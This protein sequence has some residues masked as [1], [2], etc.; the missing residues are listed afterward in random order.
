[1]TSQDPSGTTPTGAAPRDGKAAELLAAVRAVESG[2]RSADSFFTER[3]RPPAAPRPQP[4]G[5]PAA[6]EEAEPSRREPMAVPDAVRAVLEEGDAPPALAAR[7]VATLGSEADRVLRGDPWQLLAVPGVRAGQ[8]D[9]FARALLGPQSGPGDGRRSRALV[10]HLLERAALRGHTALPPVSLERGLAQQ[11]VP[12]P[13]AAVREALDDA[14]VLAFE[15]ALDGL[16]ATARAEPADPEPADPPEAAEERPVRLLIGLEHHALAEESLADG[17]AR[18]SG[19]VAPLPE[20]DWIRAAEAAGVAAT[21]TAPELLR[22]VAGH[23][24]AAHTGGEAARAEPAALL[25][26]AERL[27]LRC[28]LV[29][30]GG[31]SLRRLARLIPEA[32]GPEGRLVTL[33]GLLAGREGPPRDTHG[34]WEVDLLVVCDADRLA[35]EEAAALVESLPD[36]ARLVLSGDPHRLGPAGAG[37]V[38]R[39]V[40][41]SRC[42]PVVVSR[43]PDPGPLGTL[44]SSIGAGELPQVDS[45]ER[46][47]VIVPVRDTGEAVHRTVQLVCDSV[48]RALGIPAEDTRAVTVGHGGAAGTRALNEALK[49]RLN[50]GPGRF[51]GFDAGDR[52]VHSPVAGRFEEGTVSGGDEEGLHLDLQGRQVTVPPDRVPEIVRHGWAVTA[53]QA[54]S[55]RW[56]AVVAVLPGDSAEELTREWVLTA[57]GRAERHLSVVQGVESALAE[58][59]SART[60]P[61]RTT[62][63]RNLLVQAVR[64]AAG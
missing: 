41:S 18:L 16:S 49:D 62:R 26:T 19:T 17:L 63:L 61:E 28:C 10:L 32:E 2:E 55:S 11:G 36:G 34:V 44:V 42:C 53:H 51:G 64:A 33:A 5:Q 38:L 60:A 29:A 12:E 6:R 45:P 37:N 31:N 54:A 24:L 50:P 56:P 13:E 52:V 1:M 22:A 7:V 46:E 23:G 57:F 20:E 8:A 35:T 25:P 3:R 59:V 30:H 48:P 47:L 15:E 58:A 14:A 40:R 9:A 43:T 39:D 21:P 4:A 27:G